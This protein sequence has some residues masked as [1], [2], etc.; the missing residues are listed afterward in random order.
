M[1]KQAIKDYMKPLL[2]G[3]FGKPRLPQMQEE[4][5]TIRPVEMI[6]EDLCQLQDDDWANYAFSREP[7]NGQFTDAQRLELCQTALACG[8]NM[9][10]QTQQKQGACTPT[11]LAKKLGLQVQYPKMPQNTERVVF[12]EFCEP[13]QIYI[14]MD[15]IEKAEKVFQTSQVATL[16]PSDF[17]PSHLLLAHE[18]FHFVEEKNKKEIW[19]H[20]YKI[21]LWAPKPFKNRSKVA[22]LS[23]IAAMGFAKCLAGVPFSPYVMDA[24]LVY[25]YSPKVASALYQEMMTFAGKTPRLPTATT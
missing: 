2:Q 21:D 22:V 14:Y 6:V 11:G 20:T 8:A 7:L 1:D 3:F 23:E 5:V 16:F 9:A 17:V 19:T 4:E 25:G 24:F 13:N 15:G 12:A 10:V 18:L